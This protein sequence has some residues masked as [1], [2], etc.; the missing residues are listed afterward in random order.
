MFQQYFKDY[1]QVL[2][3]WPLEGMQDHQAAVD[4][5]LLCMDISADLLVILSLPFAF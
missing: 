2:L 1:S 5:P 4:E 3:E